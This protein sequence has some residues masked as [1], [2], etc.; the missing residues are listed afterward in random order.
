M[1][2]VVDTSAIIAVIANEPEKAA[3]IRQTR[4]AALVAPHSIHWEIGNAFSA[5]L[6]RSRITLTQAQQ[7]IE[8]Y[9][10]IPIRFVDIDLE[11]ALEIANEF[12]IYA[13]DAYI[14]QCALQYKQPLIALDEDLIG[15]ARKKGVRVVEVNP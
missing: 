2:I 5:M 4:G 13:Y 12:K 9:R 8:I 7:A 3:I 6:K 1:E 15:Y 10:S 11:L 14:L